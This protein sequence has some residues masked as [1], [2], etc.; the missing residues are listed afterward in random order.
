MRNLDLLLP[1]KKEKRDWWTWATVTQADP[2]QVRIDGESAPLDATPVNLVGDLAVNDRVWVQV[3]GRRLIVTGVAGGIEIPT[4]TP[5][6]P[7]ASVT[8]YAADAVPAGYLL[9]DGQAV[10]RT[11]YSDLFNAIGT[12][13]GA[14]DGSTTFNVPNMEASFPMG[15]RV[16]NNP[17]GQVGGD[18]N[19]S[20]DGAHDHGG[21][22]QDA[23]KDRRVDSVAGSNNDNY[24][25]HKHPID[26]DGAHTHTIA[27]PY[28]ALN[29]IIKT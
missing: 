21:Q 3:A 4:P 19:T 12:L 26:S 10:S 15:T 20:S 9:C 24:G 7:V 5:P 18:W 6:P 27:P 1:E 11:T 8:M 17:V 28:V 29:F 16:P 14:G 2:L 25:N 13:Y 23:T 22:T